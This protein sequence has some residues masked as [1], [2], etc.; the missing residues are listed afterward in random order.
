MP[1]V[2]PE[3]SPE[4]DVAAL[5]GLVAEL[6]R[7]QQQEDVDGFLAL[8]DPAAVWVTGGGRRLIGRD[9][10]GEFTRGVLPGAMADGSVTYEVDTSCSSRPTSC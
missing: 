1:T 9:V 4:A 5:V 10:I 3:G 2:S 6:E 7:T 8:F